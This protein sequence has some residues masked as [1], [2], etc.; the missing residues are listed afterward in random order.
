MRMASLRMTGSPRHT[1]ATARAPT[2]LNRMAARTY[3]LIDMSGV[4]GC[5]SRAPISYSVMR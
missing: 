4:L 3:G 1:V 2:G 5:R